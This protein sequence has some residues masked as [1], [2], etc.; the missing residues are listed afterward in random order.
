MRGKTICL[1]VLCLC[2]FS[3][4]AKAGT[5]DWIEFYIFKTDAGYD[6]EIELGVDGVSGAGM[7]QARIDSG[8]YMVF[9]F[10]SGDNEYSLETG[11]LASLAEL[12]ATI[13]GAWELEVTYGE[14]RSV[15]TFDID[16]VTE[17][18]FAPVPNI[19]SHSDG[20]TIGTHVD[21]EWDWTPDGTFSYDNT[22][23][24]V[25]VDV[26]DPGVDYWDL[27][28]MS[29]NFDGALANDTKSWE[30]DLGM[31]GDCEF[32][33]VY[34]TEA[35]VVSDITFDAGLSDTGATDFGFD[36]EQIIASE[37]F[38]ELTVVPEPMSM[39][40]LALGGLVLIRRRK[41]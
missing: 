16:T 38:V 31:T 32:M 15:Y 10:E 29:V 4:S 11:S 27:E 3:L 39:S 5:Q 30:I 34:G 23:L 35:T 33:V 37:D 1:T 14:K 20:G 40:L 12:N 2:A 8:S 36:D 18:M 41:K 26:E 22:G 13:V 24:Y 21:F 7:V 17:S 6:A 28:A 25:E 19:T 9:D